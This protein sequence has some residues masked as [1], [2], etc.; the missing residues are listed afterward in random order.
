MQ[1]IHNGVR[2]LQALHVHID[3]FL[4]IGLT[5]TRKLKKKIHNTN[6]LGLAQIK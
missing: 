4:N 6:Y 5:D 1:M 2:S 3:F